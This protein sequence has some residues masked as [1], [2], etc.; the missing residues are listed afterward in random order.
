M[1]TGLHNRKTALS[2][3]EKAEVRGPPAHLLA[4]VFGRKAPRKLCHLANGPK[5]EI[6]HKLQAYKEGNQIITY[7]GSLIER[8]VAGLHGPHQLHG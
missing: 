7:P 4:V 5:Q 3:R 1:Q 6:H 2:S 8:A